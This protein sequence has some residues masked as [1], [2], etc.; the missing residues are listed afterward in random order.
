MRSFRHT[1]L[2]KIAACITYGVCKSRAYSTLFY[3]SCTSV[4]SVAI[5][6]IVEDLLD[7]LDSTCN[8]SLIFILVLLSSRSLR[9]LMFEIFFHS[10]LLLYFIVDHSFIVAL[11]LKAFLP[12]DLL[13]SN[14]LHILIFHLIALLVRGAT[15]N[16]SLMLF[17][18]FSIVSSH[19]E[20]L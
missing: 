9:K 18:F 20:A 5:R 2:P 10:D 8:W 19:C 4:W 6:Y 11:F 15:H 16:S 1:K 3:I 7:L 17:L 13:P 12:S 14:K